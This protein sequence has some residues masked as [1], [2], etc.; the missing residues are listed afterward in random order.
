[1]RVTKPRRLEI[2]L[3]LAGLI[4]LTIWLLFGRLALFR[5]TEY[6]WYYM[7]DPSGRRADHP[8]L[9]EVRD[10]VQVGQS[11]VAHYPGLYRLD[12]LL[13][14][15]GRRDVADL[16]FH[17]RA[18][19]PEGAEL[20]TT[21]VDG[22]AI[23]DNAFQPFTFPPLDDSAGRTYFF[24]LEAPGAGPQ[25]AVG[26]WISSGDRNP[27]G[28]AFLSLIS[29]SPGPEGWL[30]SGDVGFMVHYKGRPLESIPIFLRRLTADKPALWGK[31]WFYLLLLALYLVL[32]A[33]FAG[34][35][36]RVIRAQ[37]HDEQSA[38]EQTCGR[39]DV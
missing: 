5:T 7:P 36:R 25:N 8:S 39:S 22:A 20:F 29:A 21:S 28:R 6:S 34:V 15:S 23:V 14:T 13:T 4:A 35:L 2:T 16:V 3:L 27:E 33:C 19:G 1:M 38:G 24:Y 10:G 11:F 17:L 37:S 30:P 12:V 32:L 26:V 18:D 9:L 31:V